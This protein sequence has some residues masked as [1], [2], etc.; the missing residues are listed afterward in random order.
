[1]PYRILLFL[2]V[3]QFKS[4]ATDSKYRLE[5]LFQSV[6]MYRIELIR[7]HLNKD[8]IY[9]SFSNRFYS[10]CFNK[11]WFFSVTTNVHFTIE[12]IKMKNANIEIISFLK[13]RFY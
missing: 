5:I 3:S 2:F 12:N 7:K 8:D 11:Q 9:I 4:N 1:M 10:D 13:A 6:F